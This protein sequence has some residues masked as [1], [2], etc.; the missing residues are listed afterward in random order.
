VANTDPGGEFLTRRQDLLR[1]VLDTIVP[2]DDYPSASQAGG[3]EFLTRLIVERTDWTSRVA[4]ALDAA[5]AM[6]WPRS[7]TELDQTQREA[8]SPR[9]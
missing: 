4:R 5:V 2:L 7:F 6:A 3:V 1:A 8:G 9:S